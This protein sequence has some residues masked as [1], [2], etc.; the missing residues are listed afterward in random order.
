MSLVLTPFQEFSRHRYCI[1][2]DREFKN[3]SAVGPAHFKFHKNSPTRLKPSKGDLDN[4]GTISHDLF[5]SFWASGVK[6]NIR[7]MV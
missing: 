7:S 4:M 5:I 6:R 1:V 3:I 2:Y